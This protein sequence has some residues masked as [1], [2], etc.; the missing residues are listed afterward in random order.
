MRDEIGEGAC[1]PDM[2]KCRVPLCGIRRSDVNVE[3]K[4]ESYLWSKA[5]LDAWELAH[6]MER[7]HV[8]VSRKTI[9]ETLG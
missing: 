5:A 4:W 9:I 2:G 3:V 8:S 6:T 7:R 1:W